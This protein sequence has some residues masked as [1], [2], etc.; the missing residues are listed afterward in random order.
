[1][2]RLGVEPKMVYRPRVVVQTVLHWYAIDCGHCAKAVTRWGWFGRL[3]C[4]WCGTLN[5]VFW[6]VGY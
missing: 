3:R 2:N 4:Y 1:M 6:S 5:R